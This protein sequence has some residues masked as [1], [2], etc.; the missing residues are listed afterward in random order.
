MN[1]RFIYLASA[2]PRRRALLE[3]IG[4]RFRVNPV[5]LDES[6]LGDEPPKDYVLRLAKAKAE[7]AASL[8]PRDSV[9]LGADTTVVIG[10]EVF[11]KPRDRE[12]ALSMLTR[13]SG[14]EH[15]VHTAVCAVQNDE[16]YTE[17]STNRVRFRRLEE[18]EIE[19][20]WASGESADKAG[21]YSIQGLG[22]VFIENIEGSYSGV[23]G[24]PLFETARVL[25]KCEIDV[26]DQDKRC[27]KNY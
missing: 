19:R 7:T 26:L 13:L 21:A 16:L 8:L 17:I 12:D 15:E 3:Q 9:V 1:Q 18:I 23:M 24:L 22:A 20:Y 2:S 10:G 5:D 14:S 6:R 27:A 25:G 11:A 4:V